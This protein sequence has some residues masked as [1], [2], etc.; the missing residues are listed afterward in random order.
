MDESNIRNEFAR[1]AYELGF[2]W[3]HPP[4]MTPF[5]KKDS[6]E[7]AKDAPKAPKNKREMGKIDLIL[8]NPRGPSVL[9]E[10]KRIDMTDG[11]RIGHNG[12]IAFADISPAQRGTLDRWVYHLLGDGYLAI[13]TIEPSTKIRRRLWLIDWEMWVREETNAFD[14]GYKGFPVTST[15]GFGLSNLFSEYELEWLVG[16]D[17]QWGIPEHHPIRRTVGLYPHPENE[18][19]P[20]SIRFGPA[21]A[22]DTPMER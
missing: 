20:I 22:S 13:G 1:A 9:V 7:Q 18:W 16:G 4:D 8:A 21:G 14:L 6:K 11:P 12:S 3:Y 2:V 10:T 19:E 17:I 15:K 5:Y